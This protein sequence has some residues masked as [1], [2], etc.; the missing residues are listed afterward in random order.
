[1]TALCFPLCFDCPSH[2]RLKHVRVF[3]CKFKFVL[4]NITTCCILW[5]TSSSSTSDTSASM[6]LL[7]S[8]FLTLSVSVMVRVFAALIRFVA[9]PTSSLL[10]RVSCYRGLLHL[11]SLAPCSHCRCRNPSQPHLPHSTCPWSVTYLPPALH[12]ILCWILHSTYTLGVTS[13]VIVLLPPS[14]RRSTSPCHHATVIASLDTSSF[15]I[16]FRLSDPPA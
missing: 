1:M 11:A 13:K 10:C 8:L 15:F 7:G 3:L 9:C 4:A 14:C 12:L 16:V 2:T 6:E 5:S